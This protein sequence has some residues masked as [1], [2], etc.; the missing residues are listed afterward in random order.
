MHGHTLKLTINHVFILISCSSSF[1]RLRKPCS[2]CI[3]RNL[4]RQTD[5]QSDGRDD[6]ALES[7][8]RHRC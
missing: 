8:L 4:E 6:T 2:K 3:N 7:V 5:R 1:T